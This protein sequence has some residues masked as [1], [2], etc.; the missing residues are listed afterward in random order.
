ME[1]HQPPSPFPAIVAAALSLL[2]GSTYSLAFPVV[3]WNWMVLPALLVFLLA[4]QRQGPWTAAGLGFLF[5][6]AA[7]GTSFSWLWDIFGPFS[8]ALV[9]M[10][11]AFTLIFGWLHAMVSVR[12]RPGASWSLAIAAAWLACEHVCCEH[13]WLEF[14]W[15]TPGLALGPHPLLPW[16][17]VYGVSFVV[18]WSVASLLGTTVFSKVWGA[19]L[20]IGLGWGAWLWRNLPAEAPREPVNVF[21]VQD[22]SSRIERH[23]L[24]SSHAPETPQVVTWPELSTLE[25]PREK[26][27][28]WQSLLALARDK[29]AVL[30]LG[31]LTRTKSG[32]DWQNTAL[33]MGRDGALGTHAKHH[34]VHFVEEGIP[35]TAFTPINTPLGRI[36]TPICFDNDFEDVPRRMTQA[37]A[38]FFVV[39]SMDPAPWGKRQ[40][41]QHAAL[42]RLRATENA[43][44]F[45][46]AS[47]SG[48]TQIVSPTGKVTARLPVLQDG[49][50]TGVVGRERRLTFY[51]QWGWAIPGLVTLAFGC[52]LLTGFPFR[53][54]T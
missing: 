49:V 18:V 17:G 39:P 47:S 31:T 13:F 23:L 19:M 8:L 44:W 25:D 27:K 11:A 53:S 15:G 35:G 50:L 54:T 38:E 30:V 48:V 42:V 46:V 33:T 34:L 26:T 14:P 36:G 9:A 24:S 52:W 22:E 6:L 1:K 3:G 51:T 20:L 37:G 12:L 2:S 32:H 43:R 45:A 4:L 16:V 10:L 29:Q 40:H 5:G 7:Y 41:E 21:L 28:S